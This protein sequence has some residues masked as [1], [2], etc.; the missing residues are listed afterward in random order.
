[1]S[2]KKKELKNYPSDLKK[3]RLNT[4]KSGKLHFFI[5][6]ALGIAALLLYSNT[7]KN[8]FVLDD[9][10]AV[11]YNTFVKSGYKGIP[12][13]LTT[14]YRAGYWGAK[15]N[16]YRPLPLVVFAI[17]CE[18]SKV[19]NPQPFHILNCIVFALTAVI[20]YLLLLK[21]LK[22]LTFIYPL[23]ITAIFVIHPIHTEVVANIK[24]LDELLSLFFCLCS[25]YATLK[26]A[27]TTNSLYLFLLFVCYLLAL[28]SKEGAITFVLIFPAILFFFTSA[29]KKVY[30]NATI[31]FGVSA[32]L[33]LS[34]RSY[35][36]SHQTGMNYELQL[37]DNTIIAATNYGD[38]VASCFYN[39]GKYLLMSV[40]PHPLSIDYSYNQIPI[41]NWTNTYT[42]MSFITYI[43]LASLILFRWGKKEAWLFGLLFFAITISL[44]SNLFYIIGTN[45]GERLL[46]IPSLGICITAVLLI[47]KIIPVTLLKTKFTPH[48]SP[49]TIV[50]F[51][52][53]IMVGAIKT[54]SRNAEWKNLNTLCEKDIKSSPNSAHLN[55]WYGKGIADDLQDR[56]Y[57]EQD[58][59][60]ASD[61][62]IAY[63]T[64]AIKIYP[65]FAD[66]YGNRGKQYFNQNNFDQ[67]L[68]DYRDAVR[69]K[70]SITGVY[71]DLGVIYINRNNYDS[72][73]YYF[74]KG[75][76]ID[77]NAIYLY[78]NLA[79]AY[80]RNKQYDEAINNLMIA[81]QIDNSQAIIYKDIAINNHISGNYSEA[82]KFYNDAL[83]RIKPDEFQ[84]KQDIEGN[85]KS[86]YLRQ[87]D[88]ELSK[89]NK[90]P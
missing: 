47:G 69:F 46:Y 86:I 63:F 53:V 59:Q 5:A 35:V 84:M 66:A 71:S 15:G 18:Q 44:Y 34:I 1:M 36:L 82:I 62:A 54:Y 22:N 48:I 3:A 79:L 55:F 80:Q 40:Y 61:T 29:S 65:S 13:I 10:S 16:L 17:I 42:I 32:L 37:V 90:T 43:L 39:L 64:R 75:I 88:T 45:F 77:R 74:K 38:R 83:K 81:L 41:S 24:S 2:Q 19:N 70:V 51:T 72:A 20:L 28:A 52:F 57:I 25:C 23:L 4:T 50:L 30:Y 76:T 56:K 89:K 26:Y 87:G 8:D 14:E 12:K 58:R 11:Q 33:Y 67:A 78:R 31:S 73:I 60:K 27:E 21:L 6:L 85:L 9:S 68:S 49:I 7:F